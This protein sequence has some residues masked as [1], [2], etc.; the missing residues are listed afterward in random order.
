MWNK[1]SRKWRVCKRS[2][3]LS[4]MVV[5]HKEFQS[6]EDSQQINKYI[7]LSF[8]TTWMDSHEAMVVRA[9]IDPTWSRQVILCCWGSGK[10]S[11]AQDLVFTC[12]DYNLRHDKKHGRGKKHAGKFYAEI[13]WFLSNMQVQSRA[14]TIPLPLEKSGFQEVSAKLLRAAIVKINVT[15]STFH[16]MGPYLI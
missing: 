12:N 10:I 5:N 16:K 11:R 6:Q 8:M 15:G 1:I 2:E 13:R 3:S 4:W 7:M 14:E 9:Q